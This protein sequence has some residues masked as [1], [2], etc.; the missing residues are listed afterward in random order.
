MGALN[1]EVDFFTFDRC[2]MTRKINGIIPTATGRKVL[3][4]W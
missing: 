1:L 4:V 3:K 2:V